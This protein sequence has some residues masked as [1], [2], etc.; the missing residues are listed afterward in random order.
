MITPY[1]VATG[2]A[3][4]L[5][6]F[7]KS[8]IQCSWIEYTNWRYSPITTVSCHQCQCKTSISVCSVAKLINDVDRDHIAGMMLNNNG[9]Y[10]LEQ[11]WSRNLT[12]ANCITDVE[13]NQLGGQ[14]LIHIFHSTTQI[15]SIIKAYYRGLESSH[16]NREAAIDFEKAIS[17]CYLDNPSPFSIDLIQAINRQQEFNTKAV[18]EID[19]KGGRRIA[20]GILHYHKFLQLFITH[21]GETM[22]PT[23]EVDLAWHAHMLHPSSYQTFTRSYIGR[24]INHNDNIEPEKLKEYSK[25]TKEAWI[26]TNGYPLMN[27]NSNGTNCSKPELTNAFNDGHQIFSHTSNRDYIPVTFPENNMGYL[28]KCERVDFIYSLCTSL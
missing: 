8:R 15:A 9:N 12:L 1:N 19:W 16:P 21:P 3:E 22:V 20:R 17:V 10:E 25:R 23:L 7:C 11:I 26:I 14:R 27:S 5:C 4:I 18:K 28:K 2:T 13:T 6:C 24:M